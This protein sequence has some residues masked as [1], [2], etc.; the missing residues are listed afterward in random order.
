VDT[1]VVDSPPEHRFEIRAD[2]ELAGFAA[3]RAGERAIVFTHTEIDPAYE[4]KGLGSVLVRSALDEVRSRGHA[5]LPACP[6][7][8]S[9]VERHPDYLDLVPAAERDRFGLP[10]G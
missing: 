7:V 3:Y 8:R 5:V 2:G 6:F 4:G 10:T 9:F 1:S